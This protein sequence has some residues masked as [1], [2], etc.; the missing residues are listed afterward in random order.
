V[1][2]DVEINPLLFAAGVASGRDTSMIDI[3]AEDIVPG[4]FKITRK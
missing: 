3:T 4:T 2:H 1:S